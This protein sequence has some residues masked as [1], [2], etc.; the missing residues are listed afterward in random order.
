MAPT[1]IATTGG[2]G[3][4]VGIGRRCMKEIWIGVVVDIGRRIIAGV[5]CEYGLLFVLSEVGVTV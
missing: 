3:F 1:G 2:H 5:V 4:E